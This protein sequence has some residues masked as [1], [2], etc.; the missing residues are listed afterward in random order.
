ML[1]LLNLSP[2][3]KVDSGSTDGE[4]GLP[5]VEREIA[6]EYTL[7]RVVVAGQ[8]T[9]KTQLPLIMFVAVMA[10]QAVTSQQPLLTLLKLIQKAT[11]SQYRSQTGRTVT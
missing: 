7:R 8:S 10:L 1:D 6:D 9:M 5:P 3:L 2:R 4:M 11:S